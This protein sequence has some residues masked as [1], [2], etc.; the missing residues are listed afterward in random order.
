MITTRRMFL[1]SSLVAV[2]AAVACSGAAAPAAAFSVDQAP[3]RLPK[4]VVPTHYTIAV[5]PNVAARTLSGR[6]SIVI[7]VRSAT[8][9]IQFNSLNEILR[10]VKLDGTRVKHVATDDK[11]E[12]TTVKLAAPATVG[13]HTL[14]FSYSGKIESEPHGL[15][16]QPYAAANG[17]QGLLLTTQMEATDARRMFPCWD[18]PAFRAT[19]KLTVTAPAAWKSV[20]NMPIVKRVVHGELATTTFD[21]TPK[22]PSYLVE[23][24]AGDLAEISAV[25][26][27]VRFG[28]WAVRGSE[29][30]GATALANA[31][32]I[33]ADYNE[34]FGYPYPL[35]KLD[36]IAV[37]GGFQGAMENWG[38]I[39]YNDQA[40]LL[41]ASSS[42]GNRQ[43]VYSIMAHEMAHQWNGDLVTMAWWDDIWLNESFA[44]WM[45]ARETARRN[46]DW[47]WWETE[48][49]DKEDAMGADGR[50]TSHAIQQ[51]VTDELQ[52]TNSF[53]PQITYNKGQSILRMFEAYLGPDTFRAGIRA[54]M[55]AFAFSNATTLDLW[56]ALSRASG[57]DVAAIAAGW[58]EKPGF[59]L[60]DVMAECDAA[61]ART[62]ALSQ[63]RFLLRGE[64]KNHTRW[65]VP[66]QI[67]AGLHAARTSVLLVQDQQRAPA[68]KC[69]EPLSIDAGALGFY[70]AHYDAATLAVNTKSFG[71]LEDADRIA[72]L[73]DQWAL[74]EAGLDPLPTYLELASAMGSDLDTRAWTQIATVLGIIEY[75][76]RGLAGHDAFAAYGRSILK[77][78]FDQLGWSPK[79][80]ETPDVQNL[81]QTL[82]RE[83]GALGDS[84]IIDE[85]RKRFAAFVTDHGAI[86]P[87]S[88][89]AI[90]TVVAQY[91]DAATFERL[92]TIARAAKDE[93]EL[94]RYYSALMAVRDPLLARQAAQI[95]LSTEIP[96]QADA[97]RLHLIAHLA[98]EHQQ[99]SWQVFRENSERLL[100]PFAAD[101]P[102]I[103]AQYLPEAYWSGIPADEIEAWVRAHVPAEMSQ[104][105]DSGMEVVRFRVAEKDRLVRAA[106][107]YHR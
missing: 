19:F 5:V 44:S 68:G 9:I 88:Q 12:L 48:D 78:A 15:F 31:Q 24:T 63:R 66:L 91:A 25:S 96:A 104:N 77:P 105:V 11:A 70:R 62:V 36:S 73:D 16:A 72:L 54:Y 47:K 65:K 37:P 93:T 67:R 102:L 27:G 40:L 82:I 32:T 26:N 90:L 75:D 56:N 81:R 61:G 21:V 42:I 97:L 8:D 59:P 74:V 29:Q 95:A 50:V 10:D 103:V 83:L 60:V 46:P 99:L 79:P 98:A 6:E 39:T 28:V 20:G 87:D 106:D 4:N 3:G 52:A 23:Y 80:N 2:I 53:D 101:A 45:S 100:K 49:A 22:M 38:A 57:Q 89:E 55:K 14:S 84:G 107:A 13:A 33:L 41:S 85:A 51:H 64:D 30:D 94:R 86:A 7:E 76:E 35:P 17:A 18:E 92:H 69:G 34:Y 71:L 58:T 1:G 43:Q